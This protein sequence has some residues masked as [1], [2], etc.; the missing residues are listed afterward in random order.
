M[1]RIH[2]SETQ[3]NGITEGVIWKQ[4]LRFFFPILFGLLFFQLYNTVDAVV[5]G[6]CIGPAA[7]AA[8]GGSPAVITNLVIGFFTGLG[9]GLPP[10][11]DVGSIQ[12]TYTKGTCDP[13]RMW[14]TFRG[15]R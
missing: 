14:Y 5:V 4:I 6:R 10:L 15:I 7:L 1:G 12:K 9:T 13:R 3:K 11:P 2:S 8:V